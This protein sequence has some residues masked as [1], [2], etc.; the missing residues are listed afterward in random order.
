MPRNKTRDTS[1]GTLGAKPLRV[2][3][4]AD[5]SL[6]PTFKKDPT[7]RGEVYGGLFG[8]KSMQQH[9]VAGA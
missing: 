7:Q 6:I 8:L 5:A 4:K 3:G 2:V 9:S 1:S